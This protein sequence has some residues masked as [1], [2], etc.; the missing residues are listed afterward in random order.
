M[1]G[2]DVVE[3]V[4]VGRVVV[5][6]EIARHRRVLDGFTLSL[7]PVGQ[8]RRRQSEGGAQDKVLHLVDGN[9]VRR[10]RRWVIA[11]ALNPAMD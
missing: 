8:G 4:G 7:V 3:A 9:E 11:D 1:D 5:L 10:Q 6:Q 2:T